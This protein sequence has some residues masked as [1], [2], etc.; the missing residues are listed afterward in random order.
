MIESFV[1]KGRSCLEIES[2]QMDSL[3]VPRTFFVDKKEEAILQ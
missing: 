3:S 1:R 2:N